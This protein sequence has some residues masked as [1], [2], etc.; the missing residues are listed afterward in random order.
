MPYENITI[1]RPASQ[2]HPCGRPCDWGVEGLREIHR[3]IKSRA[4]VSRST[5]VHMIAN[6]G[7]RCI[8]ASELLPRF[9]R[10]A[11]SVPS[12]KGQPA[13][14][15]SGPEYRQEHQEGA[16]PHSVAYLL[17]IATAGPIGHPAIDRRD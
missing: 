3:D 12:T 8:Q 11:R 4:D 13:W 1:A 5:V 15:R 10:L 14:F 2:W 6:A 17:Q 9:Q 16:G 7:A